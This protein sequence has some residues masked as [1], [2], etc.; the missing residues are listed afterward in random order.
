MIKT[1]NFV[2]FV[3]FVVIE[4]FRTYQMIDIKAGRTKNIGGASDWTAPYEKI[5][6]ENY[7][8]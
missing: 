4:S 2:L 1:P 3:S 6:A 5:A 8:E 7:R